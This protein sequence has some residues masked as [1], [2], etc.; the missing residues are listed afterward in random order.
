MKPEPSEWVKITDEVRALILRAVAAEGSKSR[1]ARRLGYSSGNSVINHWL[2]GEAKSIPR[3]VFRRLNVIAKEAAVPKCY[4]REPDCDWEDC[5][6][7][8]SC[9]WIL[10]LWPRSLTS[11]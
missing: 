4:G 6:F 5:E 3:E 9:K 2:R 8:G 1:L 10:R 11:S 7:R